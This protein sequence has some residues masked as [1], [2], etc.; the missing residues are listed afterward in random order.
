MPMDYFYQAGFF[1]LLLFCVMC[2]WERTTKLVKMLDLKLQWWT[3]CLIGNILFL[4]LAFLHLSLVV[5]FADE[6]K[7]DIWISGSYSQAYIKQFA[8]KFLMLRSS[9]YKCNALYKLASRQNYIL[10]K[11]HK[12]LLRFW[13][14]ALCT[15]FKYSHQTGWTGRTSGLIE[16][17][18]TFC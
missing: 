4:W 18:V 12:A 14:F 17:I 10:T 2:W 5:I 6:Y 7:F 15:K 3:W 9:K 13:S 11:I 16:I 1:H 8:N